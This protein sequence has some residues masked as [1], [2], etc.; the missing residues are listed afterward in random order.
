MHA[1]SGACSCSICKRGKRNAAWGCPSRR[2]RMTLFLLAHAFLPQLCQSGSWSMGFPSVTALVLFCGWPWV[3]M[4][5]SP[6]SSRAQWCRSSHQH[7]E[8]IT[9]TAKQCPMP[10]FPI[11]LCRDS[12]GRAERVLWRLSGR[13]KSKHGKRLCAPKI[14]LELNHKM[15]I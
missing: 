15:L 14:C 3:R 6:S 5:T 8:T 1:V 11:T 9:P 2:E 7:M 4:Q 12:W 13:R 10:E